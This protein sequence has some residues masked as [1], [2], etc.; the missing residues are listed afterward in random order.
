MQPFVYPCRAAAL[1]GLVRVM[2]II[3]LYPIPYPLPQSRHIVCGMQINMLLLDGA[4]KTLYPYIIFATSPAIHRNTDIYYPPIAAPT[5]PSCIGFLGRCSL[6]QVRHAALCTPAT[7]RSS[8][9][10]ITCCSDAI[11]THNDYTHL[12]SH[13]ST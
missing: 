5:P 13:I 2:L 3:K 12:S 9:L 7:T 6:S 1:Q 10:P 4:P 11:L 8:F